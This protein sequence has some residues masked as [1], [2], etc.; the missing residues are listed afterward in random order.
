MASIRIDGAPAAPTAE[1]WPDDH[2]V[3]IRAD[4]LFARRLDTE[5]AT[6][7]R[8][9]LHDPETGLSSLSG[10]AALEAAAGHPATGCAAVASAGA[11]A[12]PAAAGGPART[13]HAAGEHAS[14][15][16]IEPSGPRCGAAARHCRPGGSG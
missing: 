14:M 16:A 6:G 7:V 2:P 13:A 15:A 3:S 12:Q 11:G 4:E 5:F 9:L 10:E 8:G 1:P